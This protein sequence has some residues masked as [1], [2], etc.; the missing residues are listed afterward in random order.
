[1][2]IRAAKAALLLAAL[3]TPLPAL[4][5]APP[6]GSG[7][8][9]AVMDSVPAL[10]E[11][12]VYRPAVLTPKAGRLPV[13]VFAEGGCRNIGNRSRQL[14]TE[15]ASHGFL[16]IVAGPV[17]PYT[18][19][20]R[21]P[22]ERPADG[23]D[24]LSQPQ[25]L[26]EAVDWAAKENSRKGG[27]FHGRLDLT[28]VA[29][30]GVSCGGVQAIDFASR[31]RRVTS[32]VMIYSGLFPD[33]KPA[34][35]VK[36]AGHR[37]VRADLPRITQPSLYLYGGER[38]IAYP[39]AENDIANISRPPVFAASLTKAGH[40]DGLADPSG[41]LFGATTIAWLKWTLRGDRAAGLDF[42][43]ADCPLCRNPEWVVKR[44]NLPATP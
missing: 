17:S 12:T 15:I 14:M 30:M 23:A 26:T 43:R 8:W 29:S 16:V 39:N 1:M 18:T 4:A 41:G 2:T 32:L 7:P 28:K 21:D 27:R 35:A 10:R 22:N 31:D 24:V 42:T 36:Y 5:A 9:P 33:D 37:I 25:Q 40:G 34:G 19:R 6:A 44:K 11:H 38:D 13:V 3:A 20:D